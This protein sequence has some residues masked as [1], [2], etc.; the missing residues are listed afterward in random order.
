MYSKIAINNVKK[1][2]KDYTIYFLTIAFA[3]CIF[4]SF[5]SIDAQKAVLEMSKNQAEYIEVVKILIS[6][7]SVFVSFILGGLILYANNF[8]IKKRKKELGIYMTLGMG[9]GR[10]SK[11]LLRET[12]I[13]GILSLA[14]GLILGLFVSQGLSLFT[15]KLFE[16]NMA[17]FKFIISTSAI[18]KTILYFVIIFGVLMIFNTRII[19][20]YKL[21]DMLMAGRKNEE[22]K[23][24]N[25]VVSSFIFLISVIILLTAYYVVMKSGLDVRKL[26]FKTSIILGIIGTVGFFYGISG[27]L[28]ALVQKNKNIYLKKLN[29]FVT[30][31]ISS[32]INTNFISMAVISLMLFI[33][34]VTLSTGFSFKNALEDGIIAPYDATVK[35]FTEEGDRYTSVEDVFKDL[36]YDFKDNDVIFFNGYTLNGPD[37][38]SILKN[39]AVG[40]FKKELNNGKQRWEWID[41][42][43]VSDF[44]KIRQLNGK[45]TFKLNSNQVL[46]LSNSKSAKDSVKKMIKLHGTMD[47]NG[48]EYRVANTEYLDDAVHNSSMPDNILTLIVPDD[49]SENIELSSAYMNVNYKNPNDSSNEEYMQNAFKERRDSENKEISDLPMISYT[50]QEVFNEN[51]GMATM[52]L[53]IGLYLGIVFLISSAA[54]LALQQLSEASDSS[55]R[56]KAL[57]KIGA[58]EKMINKTILKQT[59][60]YFIMPLGL[61]I[62]SSIVG[63]SVVSKFLEAFGKTDIVPTALLTLGI[64]IIVYGGYFY[65]TY[66]GYKGIIRNSK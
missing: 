65:T 8:L 31:Q 61:A 24:K 33:T 6:Y 27:F 39:Y 45:S 15:A 59:T 62:V 49:F 9:K 4:Y 58:T 25:P 43:K 1:S 51:S 36:N 19:S 46:L 21:I 7:V 40:S 41:V 11:I 55:D 18:F 20:K 57:K 66:L 37:I 3:V 14:A 22:I 17:E 16:V 50:K 29:I 42:I 13:V 48:T 23:I 53:Y 5:N 35:L 54:V 28:L 10:I 44:N 38:N 30:R 60:I 32:K 64:I 26:G 56:Y 12:L 34:I 63:I 2:F 52:I 47:L